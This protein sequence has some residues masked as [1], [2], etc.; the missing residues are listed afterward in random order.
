MA[1]VEEAI[2]VVEATVVAM[3]TV[4]VEYVIRQALLSEHQL[5]QRLKTSRKS[6]AST[7]QAVPQALKSPPHAP[8]H[9]QDQTH[10]QI[11]G[12]GNNAAAKTRE[13]GAQAKPA[14]N[15]NATAS[16]TPNKHTRLNRQNRTF[17]RA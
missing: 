6:S 5:R 7:T 14:P 16:P 15:Q 17:R 1:H 8:F 12:K 13:A 3:Q 9:A 2:V 11:N 4:K 10:S